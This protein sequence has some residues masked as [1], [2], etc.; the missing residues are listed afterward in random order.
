LVVKKV[1]IMAL[2]QLLRALEYEKEGYS[3][4]AEQTDFSTYLHIANAEGL[5]A[6][7]ANILQ[8]K[9]P[10]HSLCFSF[11][12]PSAWLCIISSVQSR[13]PAWSVETR[14]FFV[15]RWVRWWHLGRLRGV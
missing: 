3:A 8:V 6:A 9:R 12:L 5:T 7:L 2:E 4:V 15:C 1:L 11:A 14:L 10:P 13:V